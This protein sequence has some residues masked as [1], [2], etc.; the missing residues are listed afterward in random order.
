MPGKILGYMA[1]G[2]PIAA[3]LQSSSDGHNIIKDAKCGISSDS[4]DKDACVDSMTKLLQKGDSLE[5][6]GH[7]GKLF[8]ELNFSKE[9]CI[10]KLER[11]FE[12]KIL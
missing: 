10:S 3:F 2:L 8:A 9:V 6:L 5:K 1:A 12:Q 11:I 4:S 7:D